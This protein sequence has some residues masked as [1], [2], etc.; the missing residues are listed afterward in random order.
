MRFSQ[1]FFKSS[2]NADCTT[3]NKCTDHICTKYLSKLNEKKNQGKNMH[4][5]LSSCADIAGNQ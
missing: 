2:K 5:N 3:L 1:F 4:D